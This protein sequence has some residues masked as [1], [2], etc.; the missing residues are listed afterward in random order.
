MGDLINSEKADMHL[1]YS[2]VNGNDRVVLRLYQERFSRFRIS[3]PSRSC[4]LGV[5]LITAAVKIEVRSELSDLSDDDNAA[6]KTYESRILEGE[7]SSN[8]SDEETH[9]DI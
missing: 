6:N 1:M 5:T 8:G 2:A 9:G 7:S 4:G 3:L